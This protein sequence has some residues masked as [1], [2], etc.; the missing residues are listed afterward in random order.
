MEIF[1]EKS[2][3]DSPLKHSSKITYLDLCQMQNWHDSQCDEIS[4][5]EEKKDQDSQRVGGNRK[6]YKNR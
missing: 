4:L 2:Q 3:R 1:V 6:R 5:G